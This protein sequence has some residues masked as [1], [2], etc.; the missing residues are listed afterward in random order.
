MNLLF[1]VSHL[2][3]I[4]TKGNTKEHKMANP[5]SPKKLTIDIPK[6]ESFPQTEEEQNIHN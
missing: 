6:P 1:I 5:E 2:I 3:S 4:L